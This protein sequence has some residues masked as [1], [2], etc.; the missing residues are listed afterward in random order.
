MTISIVTGRKETEDSKWGIVFGRKTADSPVTISSIK[1]DGIFANNKSL[2]VGMVVVK[3]NDVNVQWGKPTTAALILAQTKVG[4]DI[5]LT[6]EA[7]TGRVHRGLKNEKW[8]LTL[9]NSTKASG[10]YISMVEDDGLFGTT[11]LKRGMKVIQINGKKCPKEAK[12]V[13]EMVST[14]GNS[15]EIKAVNMNRNIEAEVKP[16]LLQT[17]SEEEDEVVV[18][19]PVVRSGFSQFF[20]CGSG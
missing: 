2:A 9:K 4:D 7:F 5:T 12:D 17:S 19:E 10:I 14:T 1:K 16:D 13:I 3:V 18:K 8:G 20:S 6:L 11:E 15:L